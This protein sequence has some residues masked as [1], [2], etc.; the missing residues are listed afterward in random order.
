LNLDEKLEG[1]SEFD[2]QCKL[3]Y[4]LIVA[5]KS[6]DFTDKAL[7]RFLS[8]VMEWCRMN[9]SIL[10]ARWLPFQMLSRMSPEA[11]DDALRKA[12]TGNYTK[13]RKAIHDIIYVPNLDV[14]VLRWMGKQGYTVPRQTPSGKLYAKIEELF[15]AEA[16]KR[17]KTARQLDMEIW[18]AGAGRTQEKPI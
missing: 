16:K 12:K 15:I 17:G 2:R 1:S 11:I 5:G 13:M 10:S 8:Y 18:E 9:V 14:H 3:L 4:G 6:A 7:T